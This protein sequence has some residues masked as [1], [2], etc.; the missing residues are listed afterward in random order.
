M[1]GDVLLHGFASGLAE[2]RLPGDK[3]VLRQIGWF[4]VRGVGSPVLR[5]KGWFSVVHS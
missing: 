1:V 3:V 5:Q 2:D 4:S